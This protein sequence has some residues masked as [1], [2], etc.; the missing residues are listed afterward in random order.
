MQCGEIEFFVIFVCYVISI[1]MKVKF[2][3]SHF[4]GYEH[5]VCSSFMHIKGVLGVQRML[6]IDGNTN[7]SERGESEGASVCSDLNQD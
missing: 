1:S 7:A 2:S 5:W 4:D 3:V 6:V